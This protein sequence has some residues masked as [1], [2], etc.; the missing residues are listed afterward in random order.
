MVVAAE[1]RQ[2]RQQ[3]MLEPDGRLDVVFAAE[4]GRRRSAGRDAEIGVAARADLVVLCDVV[5][6]E[7]APVARLA[8]RR[9]RIVPLRPAAGPRQHVFAD[10]RLHRRLRVAEQIVDRAD[11]RRHVVPVRHVGDVGLAERRHEPAGGAAASLGLRVEVVVAEAGA[12]REPLQRPHVL[13]VDPEIGVDVLEVPRRRVVDGHRV[14]S[15]DA[16][17]IRDV[18]LDDVAGPQLRVAVDAERPLRAGFQR[19]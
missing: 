12:E 19:M 1:H 15:L 2:A 17:R 3:L 5:A 18:V 6:V 14:G 8:H 11:A 16:R 13:R 9:E 4:P 10:A 7:I